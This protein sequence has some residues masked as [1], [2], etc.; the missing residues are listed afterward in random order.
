MPNMRLFKSTNTKVEVFLRKNLFYK[1]FR[2]RLHDKRLKGRPDIV[3]PKYK[4]VIFVH[5][6]FWHAHEGCSISHIPLKHSR[7]WVDKF[8][9]NRE[10]DHQ[11]YQWLTNYK[12]RILV[13]W[14]CA[15]R[16][17]EFF[18]FDELIDFVSCWLKSGAGSCE[19]SGNDE[20]PNLNIDIKCK[21][22]VVR[23]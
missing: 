19:V 8:K 1:G 17:S 21:V 16:K 7:Y 6:C 22:E 2:Y 5:G 15:I 9:R 18:N 11:V 3:F 12:W 23:Y 10:R 14:E 20:L 13:V 4:A